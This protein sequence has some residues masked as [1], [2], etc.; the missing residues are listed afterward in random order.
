MSGGDPVFPLSSESLRER[1]VRGAA[2]VSAAQ[3][4]RFCLLLGS[5]VLLARLLDP[6]DFGI[7]AMVAPILG[8]VTVMADLGIVQAIVQRPVLT[9]DQLNSAFWLNNLL[10][11]AMS[12][13]LMLS[14]PLLAAFYGEPRLILVTIALAGLVAVTGLSMQQMALLNRA[15][16]F[17][18]IALAETASQ[19]FGLLVSGLTAWKGYG[20][21]SLVMGQAA[22]SMASGAI[23][24][25]AS[26]WRPRW[27]SFHREAVAMLRFGGNVTVS[28]VAMYLNT[29]VDHVVIGYWLGT[30]ALGFYDRA[31]KLVVMPLTQLMAPINRV[32]VPALTRVV[33][34]PERYRR[35]FGQMLRLML[36]VSLPGLS[37]AIVAAQPL[38]EILFGSRW[39]SV[40]PVFS[41]LCAG[42]LLTPV[43][44]ATFWIF[45]SQGR[46]RDQM[47]YGTGAAVINMIAYIVGVHW[48]LLGVARTSAIVAFLLPTPLLMFAAVRSGPI[49]MRFLLR[50]LYPFGISTACSMAIVMLYRNILGAGGLLDLFAIVVCAYVS[51][52]LA[53]ACFPS[54]RVALENVTTAFKTLLASRALPKGS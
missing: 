26:S 25:G 28:N 38:I 31:W 45:I 16:R 22:T 36:I 35:A 46:A 41:W 44:T 1:S 3:A 21:W 27:P 15:M 18:A 54:G 33:D 32:A 7:V 5:Q 6:A 53:L 14:A 51:A 43:N 48:G 50:I 8:F 11:F 52:L 39:Q 2:I 24:W 4:I 19:A 29:V 30:V 34:D 42:S 13:V 23:V 47:I 17:K 37:V 12:L 20:Y 49:D 10:S 9:L 40:A